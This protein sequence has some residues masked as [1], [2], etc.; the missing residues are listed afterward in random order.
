MVTDDV[1]RPII[2]WL[3]FIE[4]FFFSQSLSVI[5]NLP[6]SEGSRMCQDSCFATGLW[7]LH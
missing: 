7:S 6:M 2:H 4:M 1:H 3:I 5:T